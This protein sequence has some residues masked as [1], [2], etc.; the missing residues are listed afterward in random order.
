MPASLCGDWRAARV[1]GVQK[2]RRHVEGSVLLLGLPL[3]R[4]ERGPGRLVAAGALDR[5][6]VTMRHRRRLGLHA[7]DAAHVKATPLVLGLK[8]ISNPHRN[9]FGSRF[10]DSGSLTE[11]GELVDC[12]AAGRQ[13]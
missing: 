12:G 10:L 6:R 1:S 8:V 9:S 3:R 13:Q 7:D 4:R 11:F 2:T 5:G